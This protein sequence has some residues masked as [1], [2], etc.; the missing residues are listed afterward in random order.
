VFSWSEFIVVHETEHGGILMFSM[1]M[2]Q[3]FPEFNGELQMPAPKVN[4][5]L[6]LI[7]RMLDSFGILLLR[8]KRMVIAATPYIT[9]RIVEYPLV[10]QYIQPRGAVLDIGCVTSKLPMQLASLGHEVHAID[11]RPYPMTCPRFTF[12]QSDF[13]SWDPGRT[14]DIVTLISALEHFGLGR[15]GDVVRENADREAVAK[16]FGLLEPGGQ[17]LVSVPCGVR[18]VLG[19]QRIYDRAQLADLFREFS[20]AHQLFFKYDGCL[21]SPADPEQM[22]HLKLNS[23]TVNGI[24]FLDLRKQ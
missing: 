24:A 9:E 18:Q 11:F 19:G 21:W 20:V 4:G 10:F 1:N 12:H 23:T 8:V 5:F 16:I 7:I 6:K 2:N 15:Y 17:L 22:D 14:F 13:L 3:V